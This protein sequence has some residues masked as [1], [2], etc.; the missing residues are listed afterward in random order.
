VQ[1]V[2]LNLFG[3][4]AGLPAMVPEGDRCTQRE[5]DEDSDKERHH[6]VSFLWVFLLGM[7]RGKNGMDLEMETQPSFGAQI[8]SRPDRVS[9]TRVA[10]ELSDRAYW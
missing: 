2:R 6:G 10:P 5:A 7:A 1:A 4:P 3:V 9:R 8:Q